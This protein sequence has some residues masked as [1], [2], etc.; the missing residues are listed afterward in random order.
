MKVLVIG[1]GGREH[2]LAWKIAQSPLV[3]KL[4]C[5]PGNAGIE[6]HA[7]CVDIDS[8]DLRALRRFARDQGIDLTVTGPEAPLCAGIVDSFEAWG[9]K[10]FGPTKVAAR[11]EGSKVF[12]KSLMERHNIRTAPFR[13]FDSADRAKAYIDMVGVPI[14]V[15]ADGLAAGK[16]AIVCRSKEEAHEAV[17]R[18]MIEGEFGEA[19][20]HTV[21]EE[22]LSGEEV[23]VLALTDGQC[24][25]LLPSCQDHKAA[26][27]GD[28]GP[29]TGG[30]GAYS[31]APV[32]TPAMETIVE[33]DVIVQTI[34]AMNREE[35]P[36]RGVLY[37]GLML[38][39]ESAGVLEYNCRFGDPEM[40]PLALRLKSDIVPIL[41]ATIEG[42]LADVEIEWHEGAALCV[43]MASGGY[44]GS[45]QKGVP[46]SGLEEVE[47]MD[48]VMVFH[49][50][51]RREGG[52]YLTAGGRVLGVTARGDT[53]AG[54]KKHA[55][56]A[57]K[58]IHFPDAHY[59]TDIGWRAV[60]KESNR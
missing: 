2:A 25:A 10:I 3:D 59:R 60:G 9:L 56:E 30:M 29:N 34:H 16:A 23:S 21:I 45:Y 47:K 32:L 8:G 33:R 52:R 12:A 37:A 43:V 7:E 39:G 42:N 49:S 24:I 54:A 6:Q 28:A 51:T 38:D 20:Q 58:K 57:V 44:P 27:D 26:L 36:Y 17:S 41:M 31:P 50:G 19:G 4:F 35:R 55:Y 46:I 1:G 22:C 48:D 18:I 15:K 53:I 5:A 11:L 13:T 14:V 40:Q